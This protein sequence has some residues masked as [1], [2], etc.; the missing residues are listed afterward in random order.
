MLMTLLEKILLASLYQKTEEIAHAIDAAFDSGAGEEYLSRLV[1]ASEDSATQS[2]ILKD[3]LIQELGEILR[4]LTPFVLH[5]AARTLATHALSIFG[6]H[7]DVMACRGTGFAM[8]ASGSVQEAHD[9]AALSHAVT[10]EAR[11][12]FLHFFDGFR[13]SQEARATRRI[14]PCLRSR[15]PDGRGPASR[16]PA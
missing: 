5:V 16:R 13:V 9:F 12:P 6:D 1:R 3:S 14:L 11:V 7:S 2:K 10:L 15:A 8:L 4:E